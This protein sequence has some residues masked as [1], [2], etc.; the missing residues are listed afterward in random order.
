MPCVVQRNRARHE[1]YPGDPSKVARLRVVQRLPVDLDRPLVA[2]CNNV[3]CQS[4][5][6]TEGERDVSRLRTKHTR[7]RQG[8]KEQYEMP[9]S[10]LLSLI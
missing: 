5:N 4:V 2:G 10:P 9:F 7:T 8:A 1:P 6:L 3:S